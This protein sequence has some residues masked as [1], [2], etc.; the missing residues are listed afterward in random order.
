L[1]INVASD[2]TGDKDK[3]NMPVLTRI[4]VLQKASFKTFSGPLPWVDVTGSLDK[5]TGIFKASGSGTIAGYPGSNVEFDGS[6]TAQGL[7]TGNYIMFA[8]NGQ[9]TNHSITYSVQ[10]QRSQALVDDTLAEDF[11]NA[12][13]PALQTN[14]AAW[15][16]AN[17]NPTVFSTYGQSA[18][19]A[20]FQQ[21]QPDPTYNGTFISMTGPADWV[22]APGG[23]PQVTIPNVYTVTA[24]LTEQG[25]TDNN[26]QLHFAQAGDALTWFTMCDVP[27]ASNATATP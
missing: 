22:Y 7:L 18:C 20:H 9:L 12:L 5:Q 21:R 6:I 1:N 4:K 14:N 2:P 17:L 27:P 26:A 11:L 23:H 16:L 24:K 10:G 3:I 15:L 13:Y 25:Q 19:I 8:L